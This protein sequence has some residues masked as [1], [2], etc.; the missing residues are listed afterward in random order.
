MTTKFTHQCPPGHRDSP[1]K[2]AS[3]RG[4]ELR[5]A[6]IEKAP[7]KYTASKCLGCPGPVPLDVPVEVGGLAH[8]DAKA[9]MPLKTSEMPQEA[10]LAPSPAPTTHQVTIAA[11]GANGAVAQFEQR[12]PKIEPPAL[13]P[14]CGSAPVK[15]DRSG[16]SCGA[17]P[18][19]LSER[20]RRS[21]RV[22]S[23]IYQQA[24][25]L[26]GTVQS[27]A[28]VKLVKRRLEEFKQQS[29][30]N[31]IIVAGANLASAIE[32]LAEAGGILG[33]ED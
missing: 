13:C 16:R 28:L 32:M 22:R 23:E 3:T 10:S 8:L 5:L 4:C 15:Y 7:Q 12:N 29:E 18:A 24:K 17:C 25:N 1:I 30:T 27:R 19:C 9:D 31:R 6:Q 21:N 26:G 33:W 2:M 11:P 14:V 20:V